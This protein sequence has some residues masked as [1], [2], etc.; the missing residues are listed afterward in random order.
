[1]G[2][3]GGIFSPVTS[4]LSTPKKVAPQLAAPSQVVAPPLAA[5]SNITT[6]STVDNKP[7]A[8]SAKRGTDKPRR[9]STF[10]GIESLKKNLL[11]Q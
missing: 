2:K 1:M 4:I 3:K 10:L 9:L 8:D 6:S 5:P 11:G 7:T